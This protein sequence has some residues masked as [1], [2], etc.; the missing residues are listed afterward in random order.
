MTRYQEAKAWIDDHQ[1]GA[2][3]SLAR[4]RKHGWTVASMRNDWKTVLADR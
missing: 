4:A 2:E 1:A 3:E